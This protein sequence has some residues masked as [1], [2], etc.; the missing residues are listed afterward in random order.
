MTR[1]WGVVE[2]TG[3]KIHFYS[4]FRNW[5]AS[6]FAVPG[7]IGMKIESLKVCIKKN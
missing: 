5:R 1:V 2:N 4:M 3:K 6:L 7:M